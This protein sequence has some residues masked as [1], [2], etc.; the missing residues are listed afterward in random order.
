MAKKVTKQVVS[1][2]KKEDVFPQLFHGKKKGVST[3]LPWWCFQLINDKCLAT[4]TSLNGTSFN[5]V[6]TVTRT[7]V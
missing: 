6:S 7:V 5:G 2:V 1:T 4:V 3:V